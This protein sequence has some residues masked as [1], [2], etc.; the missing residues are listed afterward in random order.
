MKIF[1]IVLVAA[2]SNIGTVLCL[3]KAKFALVSGCPAT[4]WLAGIALTIVTTQ[5]LMC[6]AD[7]WGASLG[8]VMSFIIVLVMLSAVLVNVQVP[9]G[10]L[11]LLSPAGLPVLESIGYGLAV[12][13]IFLVGI[14]KN[15]A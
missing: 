7:V 4:G 10:R 2:I 5:Y 3:K 14:S 11:E 13:G 9:S 12:V 1:L 8:F 15:L 6:W